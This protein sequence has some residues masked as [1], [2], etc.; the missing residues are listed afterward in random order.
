MDAPRPELAVTVQVHPRVTVV[1][2][3]GE[4][5]HDTVGPLREALDTALADGARRLV[6]DCSGL[7]FCDSTGLN[8]LLRT[9]LAVRDRGGA[10]ELAAPG[11]VVARI[12]EVTGADEL[13][14]VHPGMAE[15]LAADGEGE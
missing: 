11:P 13:F 10:V 12:L 14:T 8:L 6:V 7:A 4:L 3:E 15:A 1:R 2:P 5:D 9:R